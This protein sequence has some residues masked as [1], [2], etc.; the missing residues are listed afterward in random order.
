MS[1]NPSFPRYLSSATVRQ[2][3]QARGNAVDANVQSMGRAQ[4]GFAVIY[5]A[6]VIRAALTK[7]VGE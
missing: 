3:D 2:L 4:I 7:P 1:E 6:D 5:L